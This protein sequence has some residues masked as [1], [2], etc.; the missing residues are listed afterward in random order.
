M[1]ETPGKGRLQGRHAN[2][3][4]SLERFLLSARS[5]VATLLERGD[6]AKG[7]MR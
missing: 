5:T 2:A 1:A 4:R 3:R 6:I 7:D